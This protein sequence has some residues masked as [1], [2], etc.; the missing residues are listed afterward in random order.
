MNLGDMERPLNPRGKKAAPQIGKYLHVIGHEVDLIIS[1]PA[2]RAYT[3]AKLMAREIGYEK[4]AIRIDERLY[5]QGVE[6]VFDVIKEV[7]DSVEKLFLFGHEP[8]SSSFCHEMNGDYVDKFSTA[9]VYAMQLDIEKWSDIS[10]D[11]SRK[12]F[13]VKPKSIPK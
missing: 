12:L 8:T 3:T 5:F 11:K 6:G 9:G 4:K 2:K 1:S 13:F 7:D 10:P